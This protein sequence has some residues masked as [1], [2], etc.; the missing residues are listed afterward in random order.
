MGGGWGVAGCDVAAPMIFFNRVGF[1]PD[2][3]VSSV[4][5]CCQVF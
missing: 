1:V 5:M 2:Q 3:E 4:F